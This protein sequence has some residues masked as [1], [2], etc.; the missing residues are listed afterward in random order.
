MAE[1]RREGTLRQHVEDVEVPHN[2]VLSRKV[3]S[4]TRRGDWR[5]EERRK[6]RR[7]EEGRDFR[8]RGRG[9]GGGGRRG[10]QERGGQERGGRDPGRSIE[11]RGSRVWVDPRSRR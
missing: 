9:S 4:L 5:M 7:R 1:V 6:G 8:E 11:G 2:G 3:K 10:R